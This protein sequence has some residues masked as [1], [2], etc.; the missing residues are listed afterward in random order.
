MNTFDIYRTAAYTIQ[1]CTCYICNLKKSVSHLVTFVILKKSVSHL[2]TFV[3]F[4][5]LFP[6][7]SSLQN[8]LV[9]CVLKLATELFPERILKITKGNS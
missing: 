4:K 3:I 6:I 7:L 5:N 2:V 8:T 1:K 9:H